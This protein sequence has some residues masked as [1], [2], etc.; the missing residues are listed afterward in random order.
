M[1]CLQFRV[2]LIFE[3]NLRT[4]NMSHSFNV[5]DIKGYENVSGENSNQYIIYNEIELI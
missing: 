4:H 5:Q 3:I 1:L 2:C